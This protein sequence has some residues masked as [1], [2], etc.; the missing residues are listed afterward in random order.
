LVR[1]SMCRSRNR[2]ATALLAQS[3]RAARPRCATQPVVAQPYLA[4][5]HARRCHPTPHASPCTASFRLGVQATSPTDSKLGYKSSSPPVARGNTT[6]PSRHCRP[7]SAH[8]ELH[9]SAACNVN[10]CHSRLPLAP[11][12]LPRPLVGHA[13]PPARQS[14][15]PNGR[16]RW[17][18]P[19]LTVGRL[20]AVSKHPS[21]F[22]AT[23]RPSPATSPAKAAG[24]VT[25]I[26]LAASPPCPWTTLL[27]LISFQGGNHEPGA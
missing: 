3:A 15:A 4:G 5:A 21:R 11:T 17:P 18:P 6:P 16:R 2:H 10:T 26:R 22:P 25:G 12:K 19:H 8:G 7:I 23:P 20:S 24:E 13:E 1:R 14:R 27:T 9:P